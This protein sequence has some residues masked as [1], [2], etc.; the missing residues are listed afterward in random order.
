MPS[1]PEASDEDNRLMQTRVPAHIEAGFDALAAAAFMTR[2]AYLRKMIT[3]HVHEHA[4]GPSKESS[5]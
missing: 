5:T 3:E 2:A 4:P 1:V